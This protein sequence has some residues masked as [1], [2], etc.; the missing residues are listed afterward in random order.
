MKRF[1]ITITLLIA[2]VGSV[3]AKEKVWN[4]YPSWQ[5][6]WD[7]EVT[8]ADYSDESIE[9]FIAKGN[10]EVEYKLPSESYYHGVVTT[11]AYEHGLVVSTIFDENEEIAGQWVYVVTLSGKT[12]FITTK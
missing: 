7:D 10:Y 8:P 3:F 12:Y 11:L 9:A 6:T 5:V 1:I 2:L 4:Y